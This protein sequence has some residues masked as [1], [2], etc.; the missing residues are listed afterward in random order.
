MIQTNK[1][2]A[3]SRG[4]DIIMGQTRRPSGMGRRKPHS[5]MYTRKSAPQNEGNALAIERGFTKIS[6]FLFGRPVIK[7]K[8][9]VSDNPFAGIIKKL[10]TFNK[11]D[12]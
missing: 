10:L 3:Q 12:K 5:S 9:V 1:G 4:M 8:P 2:I 7:K 6:I 11:K